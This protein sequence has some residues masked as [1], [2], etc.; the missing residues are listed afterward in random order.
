MA[1]SLELH[2]TAT[3][4]YF[5]VSVFKVFVH[6]ETGFLGKALVTYITLLSFLMMFYLPVL[7]QCFFGGNVLAT[8]VA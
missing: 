2:T 6:V 5:V 4:K 1:P 7:Y 8:R 3:I